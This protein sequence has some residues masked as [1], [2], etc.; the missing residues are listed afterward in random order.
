MAR[1]AV[2][3]L[4]INARN[5]T[6]R[7]INAVV[8]GIRGLGKSLTGFQTLAAGL[9]TGALVR[10]TRGLFNLGAQAEETET[11]FRTVFGNSAEE[12]QK[13]NDTFGA[14]AGL[15]RTQARELTASTGAIVKGL[16]FT[17]QSAADTA[18]EIVRLGADLTSFNNL[19]GGS[20]LA[21]RR[22]NAALGGEFEGLKRLGI[23]LRAADVDQRALIN[24]GKD[25]ITELTEQDKVTA[26]LQ[27]ITEKAT[28]AVGDL[29]RTQTSMAN[30]AR[31]LGGQLQ[32]IRE[33]MGT[34]SLEA[35]KLT[36]GFSDMIGETKSLTMFMEENRNTIVAW[37]ATIVNGF[38]LVVSALGTGFRAIKNVFEILVTG[39]SGLGLI[40]G[41][42]LRRDFAAIPN[43]MTAVKEGITGDFDDITDAAEKTAARL[44]TF[45]ASVQRARAEARGEDTGI[46]EEVGRGLVPG[47]GVFEPDDSEENRRIARL[48]AL[49]LAVDRANEAT[50]L[51]NRQFELGLITSAEFSEM[52]GEIAGDLGDLA[53]NAEISSLQLISLTESMRDLAETGQEINIDEPFK[54]LRFDVALA[55]EQLANNNITVA[56]FQE[57]INGLAPAMLAFRN[58][59]KLSEEQLNQLQILIN[60]LAGDADRAFGISRGSLLPGLAEDLTLLE[61]IGLE[62][63]GIFGDVE[64]VGQLMVNIGADFLQNFT[65]SIEAAFSAWVEGG[66]SAADAFKNGMLNA[67]ASVARMQAQFFLA[68]AVAALGEGFLGTPGAFAAAAKF[69]AAAALMS[70][71]AGG[72]SGAARGGGSAGAPDEQVE[73][74]EDSRGDAEI[75]IQGGLLDMSDPRQA[76]ALADAINDLDGRRV[77]VRGTR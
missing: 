14:L 18:V 17:G 4:V 73:R 39:W 76:D 70:A 42:V 53:A 52:A 6:G 65:G 26:R 13:F 31:K 58:S 64:S 5:R 30:Q 9:A 74:L 77:T 10:I 57:R 8:K 3:S 29:E 59:G 21:V 69:T 34:T 63:R 67:I 68:K 19:T 20:E 40:I 22:I 15:S 24:T 27:L 60:N 33:D 72:I 44:D 1:K 61:Q 12:V 46:G 45:I 71:V 43:I 11:K 7:A 16:G 35:F 28:V 51:L 23:V 49:R 2:V 75:V 47:G 54:K 55:R 41:A 62:I 37:V 25:A 36:G 38:K 48:E 56:E 50:S 66:E 32:T